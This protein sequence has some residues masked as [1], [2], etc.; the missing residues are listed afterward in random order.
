MGDEDSY[1]NLLRVIDEIRAGR[2]PV[3]EFEF[4]IF[5]AVEKNL[6]RDLKEEDDLLAIRTRY[7]R[8]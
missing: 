4:Q 5:Y 6:L 1:S 8:I 2:P 3:T 7:E